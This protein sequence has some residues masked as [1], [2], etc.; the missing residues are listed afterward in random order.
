MNFFKHFKDL[1]FKVVT[2]VDKKNI[3]SFYNYLWALLNNNNQSKI[4]INIKT[5]LRNVNIGL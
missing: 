1:K 3:L 5:I 4:M 2:P